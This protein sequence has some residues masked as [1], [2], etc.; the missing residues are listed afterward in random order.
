[1]FRSIKNY[2]PISILAFYICAVSV[3]M[4]MMHPFFTVL[5]FIGAVITCICTKS[6]GTIKTNLF[7]M[8]TFIVLSLINPIVYHN[9]KTILFF[10]N[11]N[12]ITLE[13]L[14][15]GIFS[16]MMLITVIL[17]FRSMS[18][19]LSDDSVMYIFGRFSPKTALIISMALR[20]VP[21]LRERWKKIQLAQKALGLYKED[22]AADNIKAGARVTSVLAGGALEEGIIT[23]ESMSSRGYGTGKRTFYQR[24]F[25]DRKD[26][27]LTLIS[28]IVFVYI[29]VLKLNKSVGISYYP[30]INIISK[31]LSVSAYAVYGVFVL[32]PLVFEAL[33]IIKWNYIK[34]KI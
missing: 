3:T 6:T 1:M 25:F 21:L 13:A 5:S 23:A 24:Y 30:E 18:S 20:F 4:F 19:I 7:L 29:I 8:G 17:W 14:L 34:S 28:V 2:N 11:D 32:L 10:V 9:G 16:S 31:S 15:Y 26:W 12:P 33:E 27:I 22:N